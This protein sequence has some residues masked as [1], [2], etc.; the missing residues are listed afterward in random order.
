VLAKQGYDVWVGNNRG[1]KHSLRN[2]HL[3]NYWEFSFDHFV[4][5]DQPTLINAVL[6]ETQA[7]KLIYIGHSQGSTQFLVSTG[8]HNFNDKIACFIGMG[9]VISLENVTEH[10]ILKYLSMF[11]LVELLKALGFKTVL[12][13]PKWVTKATGILI[14]NT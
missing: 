1:T 13:L 3:S 2:S 11:P 14:Y 10:V 5:F 8:L 12:S 7:K 6:A 4:E 9:T